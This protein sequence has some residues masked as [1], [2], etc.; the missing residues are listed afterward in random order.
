MNL[1]KEVLKKVQGPTLTFTDLYCT[2]VK[3]L[4][5]VVPKTYSL[6]KICKCLSIYKVQHEL[7]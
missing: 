4:Q 3:I 1:K 6:I 5:L 2:E 7:N